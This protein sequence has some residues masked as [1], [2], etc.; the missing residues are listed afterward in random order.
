[1]LHKLS[2]TFRLCCTLVAAT[3]L[4][5]L[6][7]TEC[8]AQKPGTFEAGKGPFLLNGKPF[9]VKAAELHYPRIPRPY[10]EHRIQMCKALGMN[11]VCL[12]VFW[13]FHEQKEGQYDF[14]GNADV[15]EFCRLVQKNGMYVIV[16][17]GPYVCAEWEMGG[18]PWWLLKK[19]DIRL[20]ES[21]PYFMERVRLFEREVGKQL[22]PLTIQNGGPI[23][24]VQVENEYGSYGKDKKYVSEIRD[25]I[26][27]SGFDKVALFQCDWNSNFEQNALDDLTWTMNFGTGANIDQ[28]FRRLGELRPDAPKMC[29]EFWSGW[30]DKWGARHE[31]RPAKDMVDGMDEM[32][33]KGISFSLYMTHGGTSFGHWAGANSPGFA[34]DVTSYDYD[35]PIN[36]YGHATPKYHELRKM[37]QKYSDK[38]LPAIPKAPMPIITVPKFEL[39][40]Y[41]PLMYANKG[42]CTDGSHEDLTFEAHNLGWG[43]ATYYNTLPEVPSEGILTLNGVHDYAQVW[44]N[45]KYIGK[46]DRVKNE[47]NL[48]IPP[49][50][51]GAK[52]II[53]LEAMGRI[54]F[55]RAI[56]D[57]K[58]I[59]GKVTIKA[60]AK[61]HDLTYTLNNWEQYYVDDRYE[62]ALQALKK[63]SSTEKNE[64]TTYFKEDARIMEGRGYYR[65]Y[66]NL[67]KVGDTFLNFETWGKGQVWVN[68]HAM[69]RIWSIG[70][71]QTLYVPGCWLK[72][73]ENEIIVLDIAGPKETVVWGQDVPELNKLQIEMPPTHR[74]KGETLDLSQEKPVM[75]GTLESGNGL[76]FVKFDKPVTGRYFCIEA[77]NSHWNREY[78][79]IAEIYLRDA[80]GKSIPR[81]SW[82]VS[83]ADDEDVVTG[84][85]NGTKAFDQQE[86]TYWSTNKGV[87]FPHHLVIDLQKEQTITGF[88]LIPRMEEGAPEA[89]KDFRIFVKSSPFK[90]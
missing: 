3:C 86:S 13:N 9:V 14:T 72:K 30:F 73:G 1:M 64:Y 39:K 51:A 63:A 84:N 34:P 37:M 46:I 55:G 35:A 33:S 81:D 41:A 7:A 6:S 27:E 5:C 48:T 71:Q 82:T 2:K 43:F 15:A 25:I 18:L 28:Q 4:F 53:L 57:F 65:G 58:G 75:T 10:W 74:K 80:D 31:T 85:K 78:C 49:T 26:R 44:I 83:Y 77:L 22:A 38:K 16:R 89:I 52:I 59:T 70:P 88:H 66:F 29:S 32:L 56:K 19:K 47:K 21:D 69:G 23:I 12:Y 8:M 54:N 24:M 45:G 62:T 42:L 76:K 20:R 79:C 90:M 17:P 67:K 11:T 60:N 87:P 36:E 50:K 61:G 68:G 40:E